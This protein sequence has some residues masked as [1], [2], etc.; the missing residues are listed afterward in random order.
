MYNVLS[1]DH[2][3]RL[4]IRTTLVICGRVFGYCCAAVFFGFKFAIKTGMKSI[5]A[6]FFKKLQNDS[7]DLAQNPPLCSIT[8]VE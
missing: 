8:L 6:L 2:V 1:F 4:Y 7:E 5:L 3:I